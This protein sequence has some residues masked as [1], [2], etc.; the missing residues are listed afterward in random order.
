M[1]KRIDI[2]F[3]NSHRVYII[4]WFAC[5]LTNILNL[6]RRTLFTYKV[7]FKKKGKVKGMEKENERNKW[8]TLLKVIITGLSFKKNQ[9]RSTD[10]CCYKLF[11]R[12][13]GINNLFYGKIKIKRNKNW[14]KLSKMLYSLK[15]IQLFYIF[16]PG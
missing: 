6:L 8:K 3:K 4:L 12:I 16:G 11:L 2:L 9:R 7:T 13:I 5:K 15:M 14:N 10:D 1:K